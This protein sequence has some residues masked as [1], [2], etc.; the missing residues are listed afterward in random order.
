MGSA[1]PATAHQRQRIGPTAQGLRRDR[2][3][4]R[5]R[6]APGGLDRIGSRPSASGRWMEHR[7]SPMKNG[8]LMMVDDG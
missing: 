1:P 2:R 6:R 4:R 7:A 5:D 8:W 3:D